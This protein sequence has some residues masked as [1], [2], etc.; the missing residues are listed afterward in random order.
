MLDIKKLYYRKI[1]IVNIQISLTFKVSSELSDFE[2]NEFI[3][4]FE[5]LPRRRISRRPLCRPCATAQVN[6]QCETSCRKKRFILQLQLQPEMK[7]AAR[8]LGPA[9]RLE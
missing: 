7:P 5:R 2:D 1:S 8:E 3:Q 9:Q 4:E 6:Q